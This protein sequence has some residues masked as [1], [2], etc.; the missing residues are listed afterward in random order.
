MRFTI[1]S[2]A[3]KAASYLENYVISLNRV[4][5][6]TKILLKFIYKLHLVCHKT[7]SLL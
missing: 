5:Y 6:N 1:F 2:L 3:S 7:Q 4:K